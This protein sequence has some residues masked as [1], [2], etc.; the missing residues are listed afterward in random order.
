M[1]FDFSHEQVQLKD[2]VE[3]MLG[4]FYPSLEARNAA[5]AAPAGFPDANWAQLA[6][7]GLFGIPFSD[8]DG[9][10]G[11]GPVE[12]LIVMQ[13]IGRKLALEPCFS[14]MVLGATALRYAA[15]AEQKTRLVGDVVE[16]RLRLALALSERQSRYDL[17]D[18]ETQAVPRAGGYRLN[19]TKHLV[20]NA[21]S[22][23]LL[24]VS[25]RTSG[26]R[27]DAGGL[28]LFLVDPNAAGVSISDYPT[29]DGRRAADIVLT[30]VELGEDALL[31]PLHGAAPILDRI[32]EAAIAALAAEAVGAMEA[33]HGLTIDYLKTRKQFGTEIGS[34]QVLQ[35]RAVDMFVELEQAR[36]MMFLAAMMVESDDV[37]ERAKALSSVKVQINRACRLVG[38]DSVQLH[39]GIGMTNEY[40]G[41]HYFKRLTMIELE[42]GNTAWHLARLGALESDAA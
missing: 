5:M 2:N 21:D 31:G 11:G 3:R 28:S 33:L 26:G 14:T 41:A 1:D 9:G 39:G 29:Q 32:G 16:G 13:T 12:T 20:L 36:S 6:E 8:D 42:W 22:A 40:I 23:G 34:F 15:S 38:Q 7:L 4:T 30:D 18:V 25:A 27:N 19:G 37:T 17:Y 24:I 35:H 10:F